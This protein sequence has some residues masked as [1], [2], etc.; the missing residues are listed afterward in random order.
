MFEEP[1]GMVTFGMGIRASRSFAHFWHRLDV[2]VIDAARVLVVTVSSK[3][4]YL[5]CYESV[6]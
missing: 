3:I 6:I 4:F 1:F 2:C 5:R